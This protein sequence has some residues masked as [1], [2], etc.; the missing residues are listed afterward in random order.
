[1]STDRDG[2]DDDMSE[3]GF[4][5]AFPPWLRHNRSRTGAE[6]RQVRLD[7]LKLNSLAEKRPRGGWSRPRIVETSDT[8]YFILYLKKTYRSKN[9]K[10][11][12]TYMFWTVSS[13]PM[14]RL[15]LVVYGLLQHISPQ[16]IGVE[17]GAQETA[18]GLYWYC[19][20]QFHFICII[21]SRD[22]VLL[23]V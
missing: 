14:E 8:F 18:T 20:K 21:R 2:T 6:V 22:W 16:I 17:R 4:S 7:Q 3:G 23:L 15:G 19:C 12:V 11:M 5:P 1:L 9:N 10:Y 13:P